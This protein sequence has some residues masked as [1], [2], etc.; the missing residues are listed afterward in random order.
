MPL[1]SSR[2]GASS[3][4]IAKV[5]F[6]EVRVTSWERESAQT[7]RFLPFHALHWSNDVLLSW[8]PDA[9]PAQ[10]RNTPPPTPFASVPSLETL[11]RVK[12]VLLISTVA[13]PAALHSSPPPA[14]SLAA[15]LHPHTVLLAMQSLADGPWHSA[16]A[17]DPLP[18]E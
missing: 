9:A 6:M 3:T 4:P 11:H 14:P 13:P 5:K 15:A 12:E 7:N 10:S 16:A 2:S 18:W 8:K 1:S 17:Q